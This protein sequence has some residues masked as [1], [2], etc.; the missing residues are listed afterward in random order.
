MTPEQQQQFLRDLIE[1]LNDPAPLDRADATRLA[2]LIRTAFP[3]L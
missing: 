1:A 2:A 3:N